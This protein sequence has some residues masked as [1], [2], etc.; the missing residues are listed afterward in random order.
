ME[1]SHSHNKN[2][3]LTDPVQ[4]VPWV[5]NSSLRP[6][7][8]YTTDCS[9]PH[10]HKKCSFTASTLNQTEHFENS[11]PRYLKLQNS[12]LVKMFPDH[13]NPQLFKQISVEQFYAVE[14]EFIMCCT[15]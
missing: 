7:R 6:A 8:L 12:L 3:A 5:R 4:S 11:P 14:V 15:L 2:P 1:K 13:Y 9:V 10:D